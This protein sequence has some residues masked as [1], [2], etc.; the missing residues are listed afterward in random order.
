MDEKTDPST[1]FIRNL[2]YVAAW[3]TELEM[4][5]PLARRLLDEPIVLYRTESGQAAALEDRCCHRGYPLA[6]GRVVGE[7]LQCSY[8]GLCFDTQGA[9]VKVP[10]Q[11]TVPAAARVRSFPVLEVDGLVWIWMGEEELADPATVIRFPFH[12]DPAWSWKSDHFSYR[13]NYLMLYDNLLDLTHVG[14]VHQQTIGGNED[15]HSA[16]QLEIK[17]EPGGVTGVRWMRD[18]IPPNAYQELKPFRGK[19]DRWQVLQFR[20][21]AVLLTAAAKDA[22]TAKDEHDLNDAYR[23]HSFH[24]VTPETRDSCHY[25]WSV[26]V[27]ASFDRP[28][29]LERKYELS[30]LTFEEDRGVLEEQ[31]ARVLEDPGRPFVDI[32]SDALSLGAR[33]VWN[34]L[35]QQE[36]SAA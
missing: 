27:P 2:W 14:Y 32:K 31:Y 19:I 26:G 30:R 33:R 7:H 8:H 1:Q 5:Q 29:L 22:G 35:L 34:Q 23:S 36:I 28:G 12:T 24:G 10:G 18:S 21:G 25:F 13:A 15:E 20:P 17:R 11:N 3:A 16:A 9:C 6:R 4:G